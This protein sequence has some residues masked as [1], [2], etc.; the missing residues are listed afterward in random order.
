VSF[1]GI[2]DSSESFLGKMTQNGRIDIPILTMAILTK[3]NKQPLDGYVVE[4]TLEP[5]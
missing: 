4:V 1:T 2:W 3:K 5:F